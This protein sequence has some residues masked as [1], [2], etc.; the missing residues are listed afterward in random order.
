MP[1][2]TEKMRE[3]KESQQ[4]GGEFLSFDEGETLVYV[5]PP[6]RDDDEHEPTAGMPFVPVGVHY[7]IGKTKS[8]VI[9]LSPDDNPIIE[10]PFVK[11]ELK[12]RKVRLTGEDPVKKAIDDGDMSD[13]E[14]DAARLQTKYLW[15]MTPIGFRKMS[16]GAYVD[17]SQKPGIAIVG[18]MINEGLMDLFTE[19]GDI[20]DPDAAVLVRICRTGSGRMKTKYEVKLDPDTAKKP[21]QLSKKERALLMKALGDDCDLF[22]LTANMIKSPA[23]VQAILDGVKIKVEEDEEDDEDE[24]DE[25]PPAKKKGAPAK[26]K[27]PAVK[28]VDEDDEDEEE[29]DEAPPAPKKTKA[30]KKPVEEDEDEEDEEEEEPPPRKKKAPVKEV[31]EDEEEEDDDE[32]DEEEEEAPPPKKRGRPPGK[33]AA[34]KPAVKEVDED[35]EDEEEDEEEE[36]E[37]PPRKKA[38]AKAKPAADDDDDDLD[39][40]EKELEELEDDEEEEEPPPRKKAKK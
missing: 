29:E 28:E 10:H 9:S 32:E 15:G 20:T 18:K 12:K 27:K 34:K 25:T 16:K 17:L 26:A 22:R 8:M 36:D 30:K 1:V 33:A 13:D 35:D 39:D 4:K 14:A 38:S 5:H 24:L 6:C 23:E 37:P 31:D 19:H 21:K 3:Y 40:L 7:D 2:D 11:A